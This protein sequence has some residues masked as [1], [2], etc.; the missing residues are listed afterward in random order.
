MT[1]S[2]DFVAAKRR[3][4]TQGRNVFLCVFLSLFAANVFSGGPP[5][6]DDLIFNLQRYG[7][8]PEKR[9]AA[10]ARLLAAR[11][12]LDAAQAA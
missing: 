11:A 7:N 9:E 4:R 6:D 2:P 3:K 10:M 1:I 8:T 12:M 5:S